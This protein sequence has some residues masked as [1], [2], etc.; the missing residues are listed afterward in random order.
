MFRLGFDRIGNIMFPLLLYGIFAILVFAFSYDHS[1][2]NRPLLRLVLIKTILVLGIPY[3][4]QLVASGAYSALISHSVFGAVFLSLIS[5]MYAS[6]IVVYL[7]GWV[8][9]LLSEF[10]AAGGTL[11][12]IADIVNKI[13]LVLILFAIFIPLF[14]ALEQERAASATPMSPIYEPVS[15][16]TLLG[17]AWALLLRTWEMVRTGASERAETVMNATLPRHHGVVENSQGQLLGVRVIENRALQSVYEIHVDENNV[18]LPN[19]E[20]S[21]IWTGMIE[22]RTFS[23]V[24]DISLSCVYESGDFSISVPARPDTM[25]VFFTGSQAERFPYDCSIPLSLIADNY[26]FSGRFSTVVSFDFPTWGHA[27]MVFADR[28]Q[29]TSLRQQN[30]DVA[31]FYGIDSFVTARYTPGPVSLGM[32]ERISLPIGIDIDSPERN[33]LPAFGVT[34][35]NVWAGQGKISSL[36]S[37]IFQVPE[38]FMLDVDSCLGIDSHQRPHIHQAG[39]FENEEIPDGYRWYVFSSIEFP[40]QTQLRTIRCPLRV[41]NNNFANLLGPDLSARQATFVAMADYRYESRI[42]VPIQVRRVRYS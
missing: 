41:Q 28:T 10:A 23:D 18:P 40:Q 34:I 29:L 5:H 25:S 21:I 1:K 30:R 9:Y 42:I 14:S 17:D 8:Q 38:P 22:S 27:T 35:S 15:F 19:Q 4:L 2:D 39:L 26:D 33:V 6:L 7:F 24:M 13:C 31:S 11:G 3:A 20:G 12:H 32:F 37:L 16:S 36:H